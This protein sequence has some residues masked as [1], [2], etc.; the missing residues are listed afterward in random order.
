MFVMLA[1]T[2]CN[3]LPIRTR[4]SNPPFSPPNRVAASFDRTASGVTPMSADTIFSRE[5][6][7][8]EDY[9]ALLDCS[10]DPSCPNGLSTIF[11]GGTGIGEQGVL[12]GCGLYATVG[13]GFQEG[14]TFPR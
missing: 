9:D 1:L 6:W 7:L 2:G 10:V 11:H 5:G 13:A 8:T 14:I 4:V 12:T 3:L